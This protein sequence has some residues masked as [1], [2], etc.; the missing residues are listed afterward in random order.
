MPEYEL[1]EEDY[2][3]IQK[4]G[5]EFGNNSS[6]NPLFFSNLGAPG[7]NCEQDG[8]HR[9]DGSSS[10]S[11]SRD[12]DEDSF[13]NPNLLSILQCNKQTVGAPP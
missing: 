1:P 2:E 3:F 11:Y 8:I 13:P 4:L 12:F 5:T 6:S 10:P 9:K 7:S